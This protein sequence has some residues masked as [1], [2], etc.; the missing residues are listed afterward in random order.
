MQKKILVVTAEFLHQLFDPLRSPKIRPAEHASFHHIS[1]WKDFDSHRNWLETSAFAANAG[2]VLLPFLFGE[3]CRLEKG[4]ASAIWNL[5]TTSSNRKNRK[6]CSQGR[7]TPLLILFQT[8][9]A[10]IVLASLTLG[11]TYTVN[12][13]NAFSY[14]FICLQF[15]L[16]PNG[17]SAV[18]K[19][20]LLAYK[21]FGS[22][23]LKTWR[24]KRLCLLKTSGPWKL[25]GE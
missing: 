16:E 13:A 21:F 7:T 23:S 3:T 25:L 1:P 15:A 11:N 17:V 12:D 4:M 14:T 2:T 10:S 22:P 8:I 20:I 9:E 24:T 5:E 18:D 6:R 19:D